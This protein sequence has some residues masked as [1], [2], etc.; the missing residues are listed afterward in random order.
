M[1][2]F[3]Q[4]R[5][6]QDRRLASFVI[7]HQEYLFPD[8]TRIRMTTDV[9]WCRECR[10]FAL[11]ERLPTPE[12]IERMAEEWLFTYYPE[13]RGPY[14]RPV[15]KEALL[16]RQKIFAEEH[17]QLVDYLAIR[18]SPPRC[19][20]CAGIDFVRFPEWN[21]WYEHPETSGRFQVCCVAHAS[22]ASAPLLYNPEGIR[23]TPSL[24]VAARKPRVS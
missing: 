6:E 11:V 22:M 7:L 3:V 24:E 17:R 10:A 12:V 19:I 20:E 1:A 8:R 21:I 14:M 18:K 4:V 16:A 5:D 13:E 9:A 23:L 15:M 2:F